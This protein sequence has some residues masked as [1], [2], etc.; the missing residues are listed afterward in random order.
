MLVPSMHDKWDTSWLF[1][2][3]HV[4]S[5]KELMYIY[6]EQNNHVAFSSGCYHAGCLPVPVWSYTKQENL[7]SCSWETLNENPPLIYMSPKPWDRTP[8]EESFSLVQANYFFLIAFNYLLWYVHFP[9]FRNYPGSEYKECSL[10]SFMKE[11]MV[12]VKKNYL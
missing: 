5:L 7:Q 6:L 4:A 12:G 3:R 10:H 2:G 8:P 11:K 9:W 1:H